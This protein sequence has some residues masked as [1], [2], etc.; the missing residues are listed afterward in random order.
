MSESGKQVKLHWKGLQ[1]TP[2]KACNSL[3]AVTKQGTE[4][5]GTKTE[6]R[7]GEKERARGSWQEGKQVTKAPATAAKGLSVQGH[8]VSQGRE[9]SVVHH[10]TFQV[11]WRIQ[12]F[13]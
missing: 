7:G 3:P 1:V 13:M 6:Q 9:L 4:I 11:E 12:G 5:S 2:W 10:I 8:F